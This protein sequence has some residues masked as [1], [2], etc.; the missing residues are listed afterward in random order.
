MVSRARGMSLRAIF[1]GATAAIVGLV[2][3]ITAALVGL[4]T[5][6]HRTTSHAAYSVENVRLAQEAQIELL[7]LGRVTDPVVRRDIEARITTRLLEAKQYVSSPDERRIFDEATA[8]VNAYTSQHRQSS[9]GPVPQEAVFGALEALVNVNVAQARIAHA[10]AA[11]WDRLTNYSGIAIAALLFLGA[12]GILQWFRTRA[13]QPVLALSDAMAEF[14]RGNRDSRGPDIGPAELREMSRRFNEMAAAL[15]AQRRAQVAFLAGVAH[16]LRNPLSALGLSVSLMPA[17]RPLPS[18]TRLRQLI[19]TIGRQVKHLNRMVGDFLDIARID[20]GELE[21]RRDMHDARRLV[22]DVVGLFEATSADPRFVVSLPDE[23]VDVYCD[24][25]RIEQV[26]T[27]L[28]SNSIKYSPA[29]SPIEIAL[30]P[31]QEDVVF[32]VTDHGIGIAE[33]ELPCVFEAFRRVGLSKE[34]VP[35]VG[36][37]LFVVNRIVQMHGGSINVKST[38]GAGSTFRVQLPR[39]PSE[40]VAPEVLQSETTAVLN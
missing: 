33:A 17:D 4:T 38:L 30:E 7:L 14:G 35:G 25:L 32:I 27:N 16:D 34:A 9:N 24:G 23:A 31:S 40:S 3:V 1:G 10:T 19:A 15:S 12:A 36:L 11:E 20:A 21:L 13:L 8:L 18:E 29:A 22:T 2:V 37:G 6:L 5:L 39:A 26:L 28:I